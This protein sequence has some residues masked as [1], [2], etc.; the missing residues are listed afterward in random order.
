MREYFGIMIRA[1]AIAV[2]AAL[3]GLGVNHVSPHRIPL[4]YEPGHEVDLGG[5]KIP[6]A[7]AKSAAEGM[8]TTETVFVDTRDEDDYLDGHIKGAVHLPYSKMEEIFPSLESRLPKEALLILY[9]HGP[10]CRMAEKVAAFLAQLEY[11]KMAI[12]HS[13]FD[14]WREAGYPVEE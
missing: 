7:D 12:M 2:T 8:R 6:L 4:T 9:C 3:I 13:G 1:A 14:A 11:T 10:D 5:L